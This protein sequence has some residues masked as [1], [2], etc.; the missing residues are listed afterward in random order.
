MDFGRAGG[1]VG[2]GVGVELF[3]EFGGEGEEAGGDAGFLLGAHRDGEFLF[4][5]SMND[6]FARD[7]LVVRSGCS[8]RCERSNIDMR[9]LCSASLCI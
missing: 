9:R 8:Q 4:E 7:R 2:E 5:K 3:A 6:R 1:V